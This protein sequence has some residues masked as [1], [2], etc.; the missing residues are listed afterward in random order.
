MPDIGDAVEIGKA[1]Y[2]PIFLAVMWCLAL[3][4]FL[5]IRKILTTVNSKIESILISRTS[6]KDTGSPLLIFVVWFILIVAASELFRNISN[7]APY[8]IVYVRGFSLNN[9]SIVTPEI[10]AK[11]VC[12]S[13]AVDL[14]TGLGSFLHNIPGN[15]ET[16]RAVRQ[17]ERAFSNI[18][19]ARSLFVITV[20]AFV[21]CLLKREYREFS[22]T[23]ICIVGLCWVALNL[24][25]IKSANFALDMEAKSKLQNFL[26]SQSERNL[27]TLDTCTTEL[28]KETQI[29]LGDPFTQ[30]NQIGSLRI[31]LQWPNLPNLFPSTAPKS[32][33]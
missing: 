21:A 8:Q 22:F 24:D 9:P 5:N 27:E 17:F 6:A 29:D 15:E 16:A 12:L 3:N 25:G 32:K 20:F 4:Q 26:I 28:F 19:D 7:L 1:L 33:E 30:P 13:P 18:N 2:A 23:S 31:E 14:Q 11:I 10:Y